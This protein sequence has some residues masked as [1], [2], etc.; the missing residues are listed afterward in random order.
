MVRRMD[1]IEGESVKLEEELEAALEK[2][3]TLERE[4]KDKADLI[5]ALRNLLERPDPIIDFGEKGEAHSAKSFRYTRLC[6]PPVVFISPSSATPPPVHRCPFSRACVY[7]LFW[8]CLQARMQAAELQAYM[9]ER[10]RR[11]RG[12]LWGAVPTLQ[13]EDT[14]AGTI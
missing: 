12:D 10:R 5:S 6:V 8:M 4:V 14:I 2:V 3:V 13:G 7:I 9:S 11:R 1:A